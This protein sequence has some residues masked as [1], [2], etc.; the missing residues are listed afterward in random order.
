MSRLPDPREIRRN[1]LRR[2]GGSALLGFGVAGLA[3]IA[4][5]STGDGA[6]DELVRKVARATAP[7]PKRLAHRGTRTIEFV[8]ESG[9]QSSYKEKVFSDGDDDLGIDLASVGA[10]DPTAE[11]ALLHKRHARFFH[12]FRDCAV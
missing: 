8:D 1:L 6:A 3:L 2:I 12:S 4:E 11:Q 10:G 5:A 7:G 9:K